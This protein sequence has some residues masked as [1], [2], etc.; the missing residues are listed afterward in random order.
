MRGCAVL[1]TELGGSAVSGPDAGDLSS[2]LAKELRNF[3]EIAHWLTPEPG[4]VPRLAGIDVWGR[5][6]A[7]RG[8]V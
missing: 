2:R 3:Q 6:R 8:A 5:T 1:H 7:L 4:E